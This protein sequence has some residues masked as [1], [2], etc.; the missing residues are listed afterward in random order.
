MLAAT[1]DGDTRLAHKIDELLLPGEVVV[2]TENPGSVFSARKY[3]LI[4]TVFL[5]AAL[6]S[7]ILCFSLGSL[8]PALNTNLLLLV[9][10]ATIGLTFTASMIADQLIRYNTIYAMT[11]RRAI[12]LSVWPKKWLLEADLAN[13]ATITKVVHSNGQGTVS[14]AGEHDAWLFKLFGA[15]SFLFNPWLLK[16]PVFFDVAAA[17]DVY[18]E[19]QFLSL[20]QKNV[21][22]KADSKLMPLSQLLSSL[23]AT[24]FMPC[25][26]IAQILA[27][28][29]ILG[30]KGDGF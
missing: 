24:A 11:D 18:L 17:D 15:E 3:N 2:W 16:E 26:F 9:P 14:F 5:G 12:F 8:S 7:L 28:I 29:G 13:H 6:P 30:M 23:M 4:I 25:V 27:V 20:Q 10:L 19:A 21:L 22:A 1:N